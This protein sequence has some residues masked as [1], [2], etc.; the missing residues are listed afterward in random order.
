VK[1]LSGV[2]KGE[3]ETPSGHFEV[4]VS[5]GDN[6]YL[7]SLPPGSIVEIYIGLR[8]DHAQS[9][10]LFNQAKKMQPQVAVY[11][12]NLDSKKFAMAFTEYVS[13]DDLMSG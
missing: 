5:K 4:A 9:D 8:A 2:S 6:L 11:E 13:I 7:Y 3:P 10:T 1:C 12:C